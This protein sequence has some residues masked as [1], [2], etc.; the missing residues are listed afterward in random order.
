MKI[1]RK[2]YVSM[3]RF[4]EIAE[5]DIFIDPEGDVCMKMDSIVEEEGYHTYN[6]V[7]LETGEVCFYELFDRISLPH[8]AK[9]IID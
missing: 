9:L 5:G 6:A 4:D 8:S 7:N 3:C 2:D 1:E